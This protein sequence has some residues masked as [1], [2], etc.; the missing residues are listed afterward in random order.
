MSP[1]LGTKATDRLGI[2]SQDSQDHLGIRVNGL[3][4]SQLI[5][6]VER[7]QMNAMVAG[8]PH[9]LRGLAGV[10][11]D[12]VGRIDTQGKH[13][14]NLSLARAVEASAEGEEGPQDLGVGVTLDGVEGLHAGKAALP[15]A[16]LADN[17]PKV[18]NKEGIFQP[19]VQGLLLEQGADSGES[20]RGR[21][22][23]DTWRQGPSAQE[24]GGAA[25]E[26]ISHGKIEGG[27]A[28]VRVDL[29]FS[30]W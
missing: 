13:R 21:R 4:L 18:S 30:H 7:H 24:D 6:V 26:L 22:V 20:V 3:H 5:G 19:L 2:I 9:M 15:L 1:K 28:H 17:R 12:D 8:I 29:Y 16:M 11:V 27:A 14:L 25:R 23:K 10:G